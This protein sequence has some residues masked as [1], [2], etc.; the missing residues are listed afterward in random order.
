MVAT[1]FRRGSSLLRVE[2]RRELASALDVEF[3]VG[4]GEVHLDRLEGDE[5]LLGDV[6][7]AGPLRS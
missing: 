3:L 1:G 4:A 6:A 2:A 5:Q 7:V